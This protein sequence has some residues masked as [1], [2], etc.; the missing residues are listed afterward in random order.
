KNQ[1]GDLPAYIS[2]SGRAPQAT[3][4]GQKCEAYFVAEPGSRDPYLA[5]PEGITQT[6]GDRRLEVLA[7]YNTKFVEGKSDTKLGA[8][9]TAINEAVKLMRSPALQAFDLNTVPTTTLNK[10]G[11][12]TFGRGC[13]LAKRLVEQ[14]VRFVQVNR[15]GFDTHTGNF[16]AMR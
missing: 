13:I 4:L 8:N 11:D 1:L 5:F 3:Y 9:Q 6:R 15:G 16:P 14:G 2:I 7:R 10:Y 12:T